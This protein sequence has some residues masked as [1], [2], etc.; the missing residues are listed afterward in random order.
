MTS[1]SGAMEP[2]HVPGSATAEKEHCKR[3]D[4][5]LEFTG[6]YK[7]IQNFAKDLVSTGFMPLNPFPWFA[8]AA[9]IAETDLLMQQQSA[10]QFLRQPDSKVQVPS[11]TFELEHPD[12]KSPLSTLY[13]VDKAGSVKRTEVAC[14][15]SA[16]VDRLDYGMLNVVRT[17]INKCRHPLLISDLNKVTQLGPHPTEVSFEVEKCINRPAMKLAFA[18]ML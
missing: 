8:T 14:G 18:L 9:F 5:Y 15:W 12:L 10:A 16:L 6:V 4:Q 2:S 1:L 11:Q 17:A 3:R 13:N 7:L